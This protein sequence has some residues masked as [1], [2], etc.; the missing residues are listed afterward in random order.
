MA[1]E[2]L[3]RTAVQTFNDNNMTFDVA[4]DD[5]VRIV[6]PL[7][8]GDVVGT[9]E[10]LDHEN[11]ILTIRARDFVRFSEGQEG[12]ANEMCNK[13]NAQAFGAFF[14]DEYRD[15]SYNLD[16]PT[17]EN[18][19]PDEFLAAFVT[20]LASFDRFYPA[21]M[22]VRWANATIEQALERREGGEPGTPIISDEQIR[23]LL[24]HED[25]DQG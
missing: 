2:L 22:T 23:R 21:I 15:V 1:T 16:F 13:L 7:T 4:R 12:Y 17:T 10:I 9:F 24:G 6:M 19:G 11:G 5:L 3:E 8:S 25:S 20:A 14:I 18:T